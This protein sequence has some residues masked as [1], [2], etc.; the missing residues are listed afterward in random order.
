M[1]G[2]DM[3]FEGSEGWLPGVSWTLSCLHCI[4]GRMAE[5][6]QWTG[7]TG[8]GEHGG[9]WYIIIC[10]HVVPEWFEQLNFSNHI[11]AC[12]SKAARQLNALARI[13]KYIDIRSR[14]TIYNSFILSN[15]NYC[16]LVWHFCGKTN[17]DKLEKI[18]ERALRILYQDHNSSYDDLLE[19]AGTSTL[20]IQR[21]CLV[22]S[23]VFKSL[24]SLNPPCLKDIFTKKC[25]PYSLRDSSIIEQPKC[26]TT[27]FGLRSF[28]YTGA[29]LWNELPN[30]V[31]EMDDFSDFK[32]TIYAWNGP[33]LNG[34]TFPYLW[35]ASLTFYHV[36]TLN[37]LVTHFKS[38]LILNNPF[39]VD[40]RQVSGAAMRL[41]NWT[42]SWPRLSPGCKPVC[43]YC[44]M[45]WSGDIVNGEIPVTG[46]TGDCYSDTPGAVSDG[47]SLSDL[48]WRPPRSSVDVFIYPFIYSFTLYIYA[49]SVVY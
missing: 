7:H 33:D 41:L 26:R 18:Q 19:V 46:C 11:S 4:P 16:P 47:G 44:K 3:W 2:H 28:S 29:K 38:Y 48:L 17:N 8:W 6:S 32:R 35:D 10:G 25:M 40:V 20:L 27:S 31:K 30:Y 23:T 24:N 37:I 14:K 39:T 42:D 13:A 9:R 5:W 22:T 49:P 15:F 43:P 45:H 12:C 21:L 34:T 1:T 36:Y